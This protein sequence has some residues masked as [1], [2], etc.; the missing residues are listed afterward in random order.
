MTLWMIFKYARQ[1]IFDY[2]YFEESTIFDFF[3]MCNNQSLLFFLCIKMDYKG[4]KVILIMSVTL[5]L[6]G[7]LLDAVGIRRYPVD[8]YEN[9]FCGL[10]PEL[11]SGKCKKLKSCMNLLEEKKDIEVCGFGVS[12]RGDDTLVCCSRDDFYK[13]RKHNRNSILD[14][15]TCVNKYKNLRM[16]ESSTFQS[17][18]INGVDVGPYEFSHIAAIGK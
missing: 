11:Y 7:C 14:Y 2:L 1:Q 17:F 16:T 18:A 9:E 15:D 6:Q 12:N 3:L 13:S 4:T 5:S 10:N 8:L